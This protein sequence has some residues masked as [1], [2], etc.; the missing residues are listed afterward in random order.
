MEV[1]FNNDNILAKL[2]KNI[3]IGRNDLMTREVYELS[4]VNVIFEK[5]LGEIVA[6]EVEEKSKGIEENNNR[7]EN[8]LVGKNEFR[9]SGEI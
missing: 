7:L 9:M 5:R 6:V 1:D 8:R 2:D 3:Q 4:T